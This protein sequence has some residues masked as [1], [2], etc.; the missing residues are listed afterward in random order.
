MG[1]GMKQGID[2]EVLAD[3]TLFGQRFSILSRLSCA[4]GVF[5]PRLC[6]PAQRESHDTKHEQY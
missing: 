6:A 2:P 5:K 4:R 1:S 3:A